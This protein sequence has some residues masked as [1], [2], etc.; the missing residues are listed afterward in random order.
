MAEL[1]V[2]AGINDAAL[3]EGVLR[4]PVGHRPHRLVLDAHTAVATDRLAKAA[5]RGGAALLIDPQTHYLQARQHPNDPWAQLPFATC[6]ALSAGALLAP[7]RLEQLVSQAVSYQ[8]THGASAI[9]AP[10]VHVERADD[11]WVQV[12]LALWQKTRRVLERDQIHLPVVAVV[13]L[14]WRELDR[15]R[16]PATL[17]PLQAC[18]RYELRPDEVALAAS[19]VDAGAHPAERLAA[20]IA[21]LR[22]L[23]RQWP[24]LA[25]QQG[26]LGEAA[27][28]AGAA[29][30]ECGIGW[31]ERCDLQKQM[32]SHA[33]PRDPKD[34]GGARPVYI[35]ALNQSLPKRSV[36]LL[37]QDLRVAAQLTCLEPTCCPGGTRD[38]LEDP[39]PHAIAARRRNL[40][41]LTRPEQ[42]AWRW[43]VLAQH[44]AAGLELAA[45]INLLAARTP[46]LTRVSTQALE[47]T[48]ALA[49]HRRQSLGR[50]AA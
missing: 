1:L 7:E 10:Y 32:R 2:R 22:Q 27:V 35:A 26:A 14:G 3:L 13:A 12:Q 45:R 49:D 33:T 19:K 46:G 28:A 21:V 8:L 24:V 42:P 9:V 48:L 44:S 34:G 20:F 4:G 17:R 41:V 5:Q 31:R 15:D 29:G 11:G 37:V 38:L 30:Y 43:N 25:W 6:D 18:L 39:R 47:A 40:D 16:W 23:R 36:A 50:H